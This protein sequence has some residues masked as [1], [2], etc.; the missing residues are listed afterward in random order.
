MS[1]SLS[2]L[3]EKIIAHPHFQKAKTVIENNTCHPNESVYDHL[4]ITHKRATEIINGAFI[5]NENARNLF[6]QW[7]REE[8]FSMRYKEIALLVALLH[9]IGKILVY[10]ENGKQF[11]LSALQKDGKTIALGHEYWGADVAEKILL[12]VGVS[13]ELA[14]YV[15]TIVKLHGNLFFL[16]VDATKIIDEHVAD[17]KALGRGF[18]KEILFNVMADV[19]TCPL[20]Q[21]WLKIVH[22][23]FNEES[24]YHTR[25][26][27]VA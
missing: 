22:Q 13:K 26:Y 6:T 8:K 11:P 19:T 3:Q 4:L 2:L 21:N 12:D 17:M 5:T 25:K 16:Q 1:D 23:V 24:F 7:M 14:N 27:F 15:A 10:E 18:E 20:F 9:D